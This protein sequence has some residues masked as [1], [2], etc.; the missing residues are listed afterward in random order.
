MLMSCAK[1]G[2]ASAS[3]IVPANAP[4]KAQQSRR[5][6]FMQS[7]FRRLVS[8]DWPS[9]LRDSRKRRPPYCRLRARVRART[10][11]ASALHARRTT[12]SPK[13]YAAQAR[14]ARPP[15]HAAPPRGVAP[16]R[17]IALGATMGQALHAARRQAQAAA[18]PC[19]AQERPPPLREPVRERRVRDA[20]AP[21]EAPVLRN[22]ARRTVRVRDRSPVRSV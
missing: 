5:V 12:A 17:N 18:R 21:G 13:R 22:R 1:A 11:R 19:A 9:L 16:C 15:A 10:W 3:R 2:E 7:L 20:L 6:R 14:A 8:R 4:A